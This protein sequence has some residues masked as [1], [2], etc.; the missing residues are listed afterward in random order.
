MPLTDAE[1]AKRREA[2]ARKCQDEA[3]REKVREKGLASY[4]RRRAR[5]AEAGVVRAP[6]GRPRTVR[7][8]PEKMTPSNSEGGA[9]AT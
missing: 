7:A 3:F 2:Y 5:D 4:Y 8:P 9:S 1:R 6:V